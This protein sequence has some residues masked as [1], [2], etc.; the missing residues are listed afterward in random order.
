MRK[1]S[2]SV[3]KELKPV[4]SGPFVLIVKKRVGS[5]ALLIG[6]LACPVI[7]RSRLSPLSTATIPR[8]GRP[9]R[10][11]SPS[12]CQRRPKPGESVTRI[13]TGAYV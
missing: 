4:S 7:F 12:S 6:R 13:K 2:V 5:L 3:L 9:W 1:I 10:R 11:P 8:R